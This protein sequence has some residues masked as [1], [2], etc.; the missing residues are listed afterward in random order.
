MIFM[1]LWFNVNVIYN[2]RK[3]K[4]YATAYKQCCKNF[5]LFPSKGTR[6]PTTAY[7]THFY[8]HLE[9]K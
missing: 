3:R 5:L 6:L 7:L 4:S 2:L 1:Y 9:E 8:N